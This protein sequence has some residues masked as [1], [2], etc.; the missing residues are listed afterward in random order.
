[1]NKLAHLIETIVNPPAQAAYFTVLA[2][3]PDQQERSLQRFVDVYGRGPVPRAPS[4][5]MF[6]STNA[7]T[8]P[9][10]LTLP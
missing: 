3:H 5:S 10:W 6:I 2:T 9:K 8:S 7:S 4:L 1:M